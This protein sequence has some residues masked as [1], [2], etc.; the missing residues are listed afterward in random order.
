MARLKFLLVPSPKVLPEEAFSDIID[1]VS[2]KQGTFTPPITTSMCGQ[3][4]TSLASLSTPNITGEPVAA[5]PEL[6]LLSSMGA[7]FSNADLD[8]SKRLAATEQKLSARSALL[9]QEQLCLLGFYAGCLR[10]SK[11]QEVE[12]GV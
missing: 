11:D 10:V 5:P 6:W 1:P 9:P 7:S 2:T 3:V 12:V 4:P 8:P